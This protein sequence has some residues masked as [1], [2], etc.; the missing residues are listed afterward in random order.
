MK[1]KIQKIDEIKRK[2]EIEFF[3]LS[4]IKEDV[5]EITF[6]SSSSSFESFE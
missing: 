3:D 4:T 5:I 1:N 6:E 2:K